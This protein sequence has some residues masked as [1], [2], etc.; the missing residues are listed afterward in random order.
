MRQRFF[1]G[2]RNLYTVE[3]GP[4]R[5]TVDAPPDQAVAAGGAVTLSVD[6][7]HTWAVR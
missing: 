7:A 2:A 6:S 5:L 4:H 1:R 3:I